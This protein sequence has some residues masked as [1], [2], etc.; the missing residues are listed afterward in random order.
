MHISA[1]PAMPEYAFA[2]NHA[3][4]A[5]LAVKL[6]NTMDFEQV[7]IDILSTDEYLGI[8]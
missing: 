5:D 7:Q 4:M 6:K 3:E 8:K 1:V 2:D